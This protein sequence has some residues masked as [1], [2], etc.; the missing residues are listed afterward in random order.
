LADIHPKSTQS[1]T[2]RIKFNGHIASLGLDAYEAI[3]EESVFDD[4]Q[5]PPGATALTFQRVF[6]P[7]VPTCDNR[8]RKRFPAGLVGRVMR[9]LDAQGYEVQV[10]NQPLRV[11][12][13]EQLN[14][15]VSERVRRACGRPRSLFIVPKL[16]EQIGFIAELHKLA[17]KSHVLVVA[18]NNRQAKDVAGMLAEA[19]GREATWGF[20]QRHAYPWLHAKSIGALSGDSAW[21]WRFVVFLDAASAIATTSMDFLAPGQGTFRIGFLSRNVHQ[22]HEQERAAVEALFDPVDDD[23]EFSGGSV[24]WLRSKKCDPMPFTNIVEWKRKHIWTNDARNRLIARAARALTSNNS[25]ALEMLGLREAANDLLGRNPTEPLSVAIIV[26]NA[27]QGR[28]LVRLLPGWSLKAAGYTPPPGKLILDDREILTLA[29]AAEELICTSVVIYAAGGPD[30]WMEHA[31]IG[32]T[33]GPEGTLIVDITDRYDRQS[34]AETTSRAAQYRHR[35][36]HEVTSGAP[37]THGNVSHAGL[38]LK[39]SYSA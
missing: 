11:L 38:P 31:R 26:A 25:V 28:E 39:E 12:T 9:A 22:L 17:P 3:A 13:E 33:W 16:S 8:Q 37:D 2:A 36:Y 32:A 35:G 19:T 29:R 7:N 4:H 27:E 5:R 20:N 23:N 24:A 15:Q 30:W 18:Q 10:D 1:M 14:Q 34:A 21:Q 6:E